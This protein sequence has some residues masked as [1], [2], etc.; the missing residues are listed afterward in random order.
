[1]ITTTGYHEPTIKINWINSQQL[2]IM[3]DDDFGDN[4][5]GFTINCPPK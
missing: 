4:I 3:I 1:M 5:E 2:E